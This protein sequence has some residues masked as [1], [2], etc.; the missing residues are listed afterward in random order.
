MAELF[1]AA[2]ADVFIRH[3]IGEDQTG[4][5]GA[6]AVDFPADPT[7]F[8]EEL[9][10]LNVAGHRNVKDTRTH[11]F[12]EKKFSDVLL[13]GGTFGSHSSPWFLA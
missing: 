11:N 13:I 9:D 4:N 5:L 10:A 2:L 8:A 7:L 6:D 1:H 3:L 12:G